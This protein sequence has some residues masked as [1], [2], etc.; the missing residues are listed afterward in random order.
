VVRQRAIRRIAD[1]LPIAIE[2]GFGEALPFPDGRFDVVYARQ[3]LHHARDLDALVREC[4][5]VTAPS[6]VVIAARE[7]VVDDDDQLRAFL[8]SHPVHRLAGGEHAY[9]LAEYLRAFRRGHLGDPEVLGPFESVIN[10]FPMCRDEAE[11]RAFPSRLLEER[12]GRIG[13]TAALVP[14]VAAWVSRWIAS[15]VPG[16]LYTFLARKRRP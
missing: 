2:P 8:A 15:R 6:G 10:A 14:G 11:L 3:V 7:H 5:R 13:R 4:A 12:F 1:G 9:R 16:R